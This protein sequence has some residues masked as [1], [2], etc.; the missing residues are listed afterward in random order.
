ME[1]ELLLST[2]PGGWVWGLGGGACILNSA[3]LQ[4]GLC[5]TGKPLISHPLCQSCSWRG[6]H[7]VYLLVV[8]QERT[9]CPWRGN[10]F[11]RD[12]SVG[13]CLGQCMRTQTSD[14]LPSE[15]WSQGPISNNIVRAPALSSN[16]V[17]APVGHAALC[18]A[19]VEVG[20]SV[21]I[22]ILSFCPSTISFDIHELLLS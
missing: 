9:R 22:G 18:W 13:L 14:Q 11:M 19:M 4:K 20:E 8:H 16:T 1:F 17:W 7:T 10:L 6:E 2:E 21:G 15:A 12:A 3:A 5:C